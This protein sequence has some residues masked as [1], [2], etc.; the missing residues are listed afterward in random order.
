MGDYMKENLK[1]FGSIINIRQILIGL[2][3]LLLGT[4]IYVVDRPPNQTYFV[5][6]SFVNISL[7]NIL[8]NLFG[9]VGNSLPSFVHVFS[10]IFITA[11]LLQCQ[12]KGYI[13]ICSSCF[14]TDFIFE[15]GQ[16][17]NSLFL[18]IIPSWF[19]SIP[20]LENA[21]SYFFYGTF[22]FIDLFAITT[23]TVIAYFILLA[24]NK[25][26]NRMMV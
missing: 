26:K 20:L 1:A 10:F 17:F 11:G 19:E 25:S 13:I 3:V 6:K 14:L 18:K 15:L 16:K 12:K 24:T 8:P 2:T 23:G 22:D 5:Y 7:H 4:L 9:F 21:K